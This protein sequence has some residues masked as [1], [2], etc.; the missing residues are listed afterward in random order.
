MAGN[1]LS[2]ETTLPPPL[3]I[4]V[5]VPVYN[6]E[7]L[8]PQLATRLGPVLQS[9]ASRFEVI[10][11]ND[12]SEDGSWGVI[13]TLVQE[14]EWIRGINL[15]RQYGQHNSLLCGIR[16]ARHDILVTMDD[17]LQQPPEEIPRLLEKLSHGYDVVYGV[18]AQRKHGLWR[19]TASALTRLAL[20][21]VTGSEA[22]RDASSFRAFHTG[23]REVF[24]GFQGPFVS[25]DALL[26]WGT[27]R[28]GVVSVRHEPRRIGKSNYTFLRLL[29]HGFNMLT[30]FSALPLRA[31]SLVGFGF[32]LFGI[33]VF[34]YILIRYWIEGGSI[35]GFP[36][37]ASIIAIFSGA[38]LFALGMIGEYLGRV[39]F[40]SMGRPS[41]FVR[42]TV[43]SS[44]SSKGDSTS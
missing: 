19:N 10:L 13:S 9:L 20:Q 33:L 24:S 40:N 6:C 29:A 37:L 34:L 44:V 27:K 14:Y 32:T 39:H 8:L 38:Q 25:I 12:G 35:P 15:M 7:L 30:G 2:H 28:F 21:S 22:A 5:V 3:T 42:E 31:A 36:F 1:T 26:S 23:L 11:V 4:S 41:S 18:P 16:A 43:E 17:D